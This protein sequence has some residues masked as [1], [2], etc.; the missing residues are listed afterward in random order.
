[1]VSHIALITPYRPIW[2]YNQPQFYTFSHSLVV[3][4][5]W[6]VLR[7]QPISHSAVLHVV[8]YMLYACMLYSRWAAGLMVVC[9]VGQLYTY[10]RRWKISTNRVRKYKRCS[11]SCG[12]E[13][14]STCPRKR[15][16]PKGS[17]LIPWTS[18][19]FSD[20]ALK[21]TPFAC[22]PALGLTQ[23][24]HCWE[25]NIGLFDDYSRNTASYYNLVITWAL[26]KLHVWPS[27]QGPLSL[28][29]RPVRGM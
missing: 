7:D 9:H 18:A 23:W 6:D 22:L 28:L 14:Y 1:M 8:L 17:H 3:F 12:M 26:T 27:I 2:A 13:K 20:T 24:I 16:S 15:C 19:V 29:H 25:Y 4:P 5:L 10:L 11:F 21:W